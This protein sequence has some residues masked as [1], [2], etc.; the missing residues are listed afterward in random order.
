MARPIGQFTHEYVVDVRSRNVPLGHAT[1]AIAAESE[2][3]P[4][5][6]AV[7]SVAVN[8]TP[9]TLFAAHFVHSVA[10]TALV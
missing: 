10:P 5:S 8:S 6:Q 3:F 4:T 7:H 9:V 2:I 1:Q